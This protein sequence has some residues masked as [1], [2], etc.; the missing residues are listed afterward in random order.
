MIASVCGVVLPRFLF[1][2][3]ESLPPCHSIANKQ[4][5]W[6]CQHCSVCS[7]LV[8]G[9]VHSQPTWALGLWSVVEI[10]YGCKVW[11]LSPTLEVW[12]LSVGFTSPWVPQLQWLA[13]VVWFS[14][15]SFQIS[16]WILQWIVSNS[17]V[18]W[19]GKECYTSKGSDEP[20]K[21]CGTFQKIWIWD[22]SATMEVWGLQVLGFPNYNG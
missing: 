2:W 19:H 3:Y 1:N 22:L 15:G 13:L 7:G 21:R 18:S 16:S 5:G 8:K 14:Q 4:H 6:W 9:L 11:D 12:D 17:N 10:G 20:D